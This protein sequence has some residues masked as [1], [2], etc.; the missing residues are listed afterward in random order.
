MIHLVVVPILA[1]LLASCGGSGGI[2]GEALPTW[3]GGM[4]KDV[5]PRPGTPEY[6]EHKKRLEGRSKVDARP[7]PEKPGDKKGTSD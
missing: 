7:S 2:V 1:M 6:E 4:P 3:A 5:P